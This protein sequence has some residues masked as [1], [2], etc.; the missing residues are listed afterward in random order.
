MGRIF[1]ETP[2]E[3][4]EIQSRY[5]EWFRQ[6]KR[7]RNLRL[8]EFDPIIFNDN[9]NDFLS[10]ERFIDSPGQDVR[11]K[12][13]CGFVQAIQAK[14]SGGLRLASRVSN[15]NYP[16]NALK[17]E[18]KHVKADGTHPP[19]L[20]LVKLRVS[21]V[22]SIVLASFTPHTVRSFLNYLVAKTGESKQVF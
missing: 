3:T 21:S 20:S 17:V 11:Y 12:L 2:A 7:N 1:G 8:S 6:H 19:H 14:T 5:E 10:I 4:W 22:W 15:D 18:K 16:S 9:T 13:G